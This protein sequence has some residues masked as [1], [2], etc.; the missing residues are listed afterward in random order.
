[1]RSKHNNQVMTVSP[2]HPGVDANG[3]MINMGY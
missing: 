3:I 1:M 2:W